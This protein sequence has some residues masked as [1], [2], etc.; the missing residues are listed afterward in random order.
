MGGGGGGGGNYYPQ[1]NGVYRPNGNGIGYPGYYQKPYGGNPSPPYYQHYNHNPFHSWFSGGDFSGNIAKP[2]IN[3]P[4]VPSFGGALGTRS[5][6]NVT[7]S[8]NTNQ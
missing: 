4:L 1:G 6:N 8:K 2:H 5:D 7:V 3:V